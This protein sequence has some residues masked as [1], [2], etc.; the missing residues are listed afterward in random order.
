MLLQLNKKKKRRKKRSRTTVNAPDSFLE[1]ATPL[2][3]Y[4]F[5]LLSAENLCHVK[6]PRGPAVVKRRGEKNVASVSWIHYH[7]SETMADKSDCFSLNLP[8]PPF[9]AGSGE[10]FAIK[11]VELSSS[12]ALALLTPFSEIKGFQEQGARF[13]RRITGN[14]TKL[15]FKSFPAV[16]NSSYIWPRNSLI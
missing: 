16:N 12:I 15:A 6:R 9:F 4:L 14:M 3:I 5:I 11:T 2:F 8:P 7:V 13:W 1:P 10:S